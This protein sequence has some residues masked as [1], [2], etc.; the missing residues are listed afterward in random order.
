VPADLVDE[1]GL[2]DRGREI[3]AVAGERLVVGHGVADTGSGG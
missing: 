1:A 2:V 3:A